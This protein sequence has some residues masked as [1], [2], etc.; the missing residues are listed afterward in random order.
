MEPDTDN[1]T[2]THVEPEG[3]GIRKVYAQ[4]LQ[5]NTWST[6]DFGYGATKWKLVRR[7]EDIQWPT[8]S[9]EQVLERGR[10][11]E[12]ERAESV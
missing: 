11:L 12:A 6:V 4:D 5:G 9:M 7:F 10:R 3:L 8:P 2:V 1:L